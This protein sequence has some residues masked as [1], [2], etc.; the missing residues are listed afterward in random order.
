MDIEDIS[1]PWGKTPRY[2]Y[3]IYQD[4]DGTLKEKR[5]FI[6]TSDLDQVSSTKEKHKDSSINLIKTRKLRSR[7]SK[8]VPFF[9]LR[10]TEPR[11]I[12]QCQK[13]CS[14]NSRNSYADTKSKI[15][16]FSK[17]DF[18]LI[19]KKIETI[20]FLKY[21]YDA[22]LFVQLERLVGHHPIDRL[23]CLA[24]TSGNTSSIET[25]KR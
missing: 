20:N 18:V 1:Y 3:E 12:C 19:L 23:Q 16:G 6:H 5:E 9:S 7:S 14:Q 21:P 8:N 11:T 13:S 22:R 10:T 15:W 24:L 25:Q 2:Q 17:S 4:D